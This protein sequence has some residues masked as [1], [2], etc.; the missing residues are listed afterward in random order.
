VIERFAALLGRGYR[1]PELIDDLL[2]A[3]ELS[4]ATRPE[5]LLERYFFF[6][7]QWIDYALRYIHLLSHCSTEVHEALVLASQRV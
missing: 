4:E 7:G 5:R 1:D 6:V 3:C 2:L